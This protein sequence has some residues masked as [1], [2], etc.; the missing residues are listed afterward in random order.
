MYYF[1]LP[2]FYRFYAINTILITLSLENPDF[3]SWPKI[4][5]LGQEGNFPFFYWNG[6]GLLN[7]DNRFTDYPNLT[8]VDERIH[9]K[10][11]FDCS[12]PLLEENDFYD[13]TQNIM[14]SLNENGSNEIIISNPL[15]LKY[16]QKEYPL[17][18]FIGSPFYEAYDT[19]FQYLDSLK[20]VKCFINTINPQIPKNK[21][22]LSLIEP[23][24]NCPNFQSCILTDWHNT[25][26]F[27]QF[28]A[29][30]QCLKSKYRVLSQEEI[31]N[32]YKQGINHFYFDIR[33]M[34]NLSENILIDI[35]LQVFIKPEFR[36]IVFI[37][38]KEGIS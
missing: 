2:N 36:D 17:Y 12:N 34:P 13:V 18:N 26:N 9:T 29:F 31:K 28:S 32:Y 22:E 6:S 23:C 8:S 35:Y 20:R 11:I 4:C 27:S 37:K 15:F 38:L 16:V 21:I 10:V 33:T 3:F 25:Y 30:S 7:E 5:F 1:T 14:L 19:Q 24:P